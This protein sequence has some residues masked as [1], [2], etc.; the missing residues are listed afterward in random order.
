MN[1]FVRV[2]EAGSLS[3]AARGL[4]ISVPAVSRQMHALERSLGGPL[5]LRTTRKLTVTEAGRRYYEHCI[6][7]LSEI[8]AA[9]E[10]VRAQKSVEGVLSVTAPVTLGLARVV[11]QLDSL[12]ATHPR[13][14]ID[15]RLEDQPIDLVSDGVDVA[16]RSGGPVPDSDAI[17]A[18]PLFSFHRILVASPSYLARRR[19]PRS[20]R[21]LDTHDALVHLGAHAAVAGVWE[22]VSG[23]DTE[24]IG[25]RGA[26]RTNNVFALRD[27]AVAGLGIA[28][29]A[30][31][32]VDE[33]LR[34]GALVR[35]LP[36]W[37]SQVVRVHVLSRT[38]ARG[39]V[40][41][42]AFVEHL[43]RTAPT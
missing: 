29:L 36:R 35:V 12:L 42:R 27:A 3:A 34:C 4:G 11:P 33:Q 20:I 9:R 21:A 10:V 8:D 31:W 6:R 19:A 18:R 26:L 38:D 2:V 41:V 5:T 37:R 43:M 24:R 28:L 13:L 25:V 16:I 23:K 30:E 22:L 32:L 14:R 1:T 39:S 7:V 40:R 15:L 17:V